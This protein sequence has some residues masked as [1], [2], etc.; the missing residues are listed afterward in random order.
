M[1]LHHNLDP[2]QP[3]YDRYSILELSNTHH[4]FCIED[5]E[6]SRRARVI[7]QNRGQDR[8]FK[9]VEK[10]I[11]EQFSPNLKDAFKPLEGDIVMIKKLSKLEKNSTIG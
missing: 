9:L 3:A 4:P 8:S 1:S 10:K 7:M 2:Q 11:L 6:L 5:I